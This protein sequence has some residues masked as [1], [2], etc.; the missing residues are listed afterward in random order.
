MSSEF[1]INSL[2]CNV[3]ATHKSL[4]NELAKMQ[5]DEGKKSD[6]EH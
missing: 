6:F 5:N 4:E 2:I 3:T 1:A